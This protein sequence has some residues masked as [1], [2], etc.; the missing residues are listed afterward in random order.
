MLPLMQDRRALPIYQTEEAIVAAALGPGRFI[1]EA[2]TG[3]GKSTQVP[4]MLL[5]R[6][7]AGAGQIVV[8]QP[9]R[10]AARLLAARVARERGVALGGEVGY[11]VRFEGAASAATRILYV[12]E[13]VLLRQLLD[14]PE[15]RGVSVVLFDEFHE[16]HLYGDVTLARAA[17]LQRGARPDL[18]IGVM[19]A[20]LDRG[21]LEAWLTPCAVVRSEG[22]QFPVAIEYLSKAE[23]DAPIWELAARAFERLAAEGL[24]GDV[25]VFLPGAY[26][27]ARTLAALRETPAAR[28]RLLLPLHGELPPEAQ[29]AAVAPSDTPKII[30]ATNVAE[31]SLTIEGVRAVIDSGLARIPRY[32]PRRGINTLLVEPISRASADQRAGRAG[33]LGPGR[34]IRLWT[35][36]EHRARPAAEAPEIHRLDL[37]EAILGLKAGGARDL[38]A[39]RWFEPPEPRV[40]ERAEALLRDLGATDER[41]AITPLGRRMAEFPLHPRY[42]RMLLEAGARGV[43]RTVALLAALTQGR[44]LLR[45]D[46]G[47][48]A[49]DEREDRLGPAASDFFLLARAWNYARQ[50]RYDPER[51]GRLG[52]QANAARQVGPL[53]D[54]FLRQAE[55]AG[56]PVGEDA[57]ADEDVQ[58]CILAGFA[59]HVARRL[60]GGTLRCALTHGRKGRLDR[61]SAVQDAPLLVAA[62]IREIEGRDVEVV[63]SLATAIREEW[64]DELFPG[65]RREEIGVVYD[66]AAKRVLAVRRRM[67]RG[68]I[69]DERPG[70]EPPAEA[71]AKLL[72]DEAVGGSLQLAHWNE[73]VEQWIARVNFVAR[74]APEAGVPA[75]GP[76]ERR[77]LIERI[78]LGAFSQKELRERPVWPAVRG[79]L[80]PA[81]QALVERLAPEHAVLPGGR[82]A[83]ILYSETGEPYLAAKIQD[84]YGLDAS[85]RILGGR[86][87]VTV[88][89]LG[90]N[91][92][93]V[94]ITRDLE[95]FWRDTYPKVRQELRRKYPKH[96]WR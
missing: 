15:L 7:A 3:S 33:R 87:P 6:G 40:L 73:T 96:E 57:G 80:N 41:G 84:L 63:L 14:D 46:G 67:F 17:E 83:R 22:R 25:L 23:P 91:F 18:R 70:G 32:D 68:L 76:A 12:T 59:D 19:S 93:P 86:Y 4:Q 2:P 69:L 42:A 81:Q 71:A 79:W 39:F 64:L 28:G 9:R 5:D 89:I 11:R 38:T 13:G 16:R 43:V 56:L 30:C 10:I 37:S 49:R 60:D 53:F 51:C 44:G 20:T 61:G 26:E 78:C 62:E 74:A 58:K 90:P 24:E 85:P 27:I 36:R 92:R 48:E 54:L 35:E 65:E 55:R 88:Q 72:A 21:P 47:R 50:C 66:R 52:I 94:Q 95:G 45:R 8:L 75:I 82:R 1:V 77:T 34:C 31:T 29:D